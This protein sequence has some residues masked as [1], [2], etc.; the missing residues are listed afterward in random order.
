MPLLKDEAKYVRLSMLRLL[1]AIVGIKDEPLYRYVVKHD[2]FVP[3]FE[4]LA[5]TPRENLLHSALLEL[6]DYILKQNLKTL[7][8]YLIDK[9][10]SE[11]Q[12]TSE[13]IYS[14]MRVKFEILQGEAHGRLTETAQ[15]ALE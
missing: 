12:A 15:T 5:H 6:L 8:V 1:R 9:H 4:L 13:A 10:P 2:L 3:I 11:L 14:G 7:V